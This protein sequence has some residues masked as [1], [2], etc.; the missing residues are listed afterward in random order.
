MGL[1]KRADLTKSPATLGQA[2]NML[3]GGTIVAIILGVAVVAG[4]RIQGE[5]SQRAEGLM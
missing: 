5:I 1:F 2:G 3:I 4:T